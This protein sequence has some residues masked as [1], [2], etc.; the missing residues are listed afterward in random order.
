VKYYLLSA[1]TTFVSFKK[2]NITTKKTLLTLPSSFNAALAP[3]YPSSA[4]LAGSLLYWL[5][6][7]CFPHILLYFE[8]VK[9]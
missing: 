9:S 8:G 1:N 2:G 6:V 4:S 3:G 7:K 5:F